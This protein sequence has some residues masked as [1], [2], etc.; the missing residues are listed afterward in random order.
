MPLTQLKE[1]LS[2]KTAE[3]GVS[4]VTAIGGSGVT[5]PIYGCVAKRLLTIDRSGGGQVV[6]FD[7]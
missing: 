4:A 2:A 3:L 1:A 6:K 5:R 7:V